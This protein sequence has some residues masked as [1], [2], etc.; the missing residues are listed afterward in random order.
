MPD[1]SLRSGNRSSSSVE[2]AFHVTKFLDLKSAAI[3]S[4]DPCLFS[5]P[6]RSLHEN[7]NRPSIPLVHSSASS[8][9]RCCYADFDPFRWFSLRI[10]SW[11]TIR[12][13]SAS[14]A[15]PVSVFRGGFLYQVCPR[16][17]FA[18]FVSVTFKLRAEE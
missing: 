2:C 16:L 12:S 8:A 17:A 7:V 6:N 15:E 3:D 9:A 18:H 4:I 5:L 14:A 1:L 11:A 13:A 10:S